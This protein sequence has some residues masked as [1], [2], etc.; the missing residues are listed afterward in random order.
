MNREEAAPVVRDEDVLRHLLLMEADAA[1][2][3]EDAQTEADRRIAE[4]ENRAR[5]RYDERY[6]A[7]AAKQEDRYQAELAGV[8]GEFQSRLEEYRQSLLSLALH[9]DDFN[10]LV[11]EL[12]RRRA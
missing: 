4:G 9:G 7:A 10:A 8:N 3:V 11:D 5:A 2:L 12:L 1:A 6:A